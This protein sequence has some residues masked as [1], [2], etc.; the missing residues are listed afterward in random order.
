MFPQ[1][2]IPIAPPLVVGGP[3]GWGAPSSPVYLRSRLIGFHE[4]QQWNKGGIIDQRELLRWPGWFLYGGPTNVQS[5]PAIEQS[6]KDWAFFAA[7]PDIGENGFWAVTERIP[8]APP[9]T[10]AGYKWPRGAFR[11]EWS[12][13]QSPPQ[14]YRL[15]QTSPVAWNWVPAKETAGGLETLAFLLLPP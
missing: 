2:F 15:Q 9:G 12:Q 8:I 14:R 11:W 4:M 13:E 1:G 6:I 10:L 3:P 7:R 5:A